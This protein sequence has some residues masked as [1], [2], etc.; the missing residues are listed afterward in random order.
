M[1]ILEIIEKKR[2]KKELTQKEIDFFVQEYT[3]EKIPD[4]Q[5]GALLMAIF[6]NGMSKTEI[7][8][9]TNSMIH[10]GKVVNL[11]DI[12][13]AKIDKHSTGGVGDKHHSF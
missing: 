2:D 8:D 4:Y 1:N 3:K 11:D 5:A 9:L 10:S 12:P 13:G 6:L 7:A